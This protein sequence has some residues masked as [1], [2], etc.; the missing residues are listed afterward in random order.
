ML[1][2]YGGWV[3]VDFVNTKKY[4]L[5]NQRY[6]T[7]AKLMQKRVSEMILSKQ[8]ATVAIAIALAGDGFLA[9]NIKSKNISDKY[10][11]NLSAKFRKN[12]LYKNIWIQIIDKNL[13]SL[14]RSWTDKKG[15]N[16]RDIR[17]DIADAI[18]KKEVIYSISV[19]KFDLSI[20]AIV[21]IFE[22]KEIVGALEVISHFNSIEKQMKK[23]DVDSMV[24]LDK[25]YTKQL[26][27][28]YTNIFVDEYY[29]A[30][31]DA[32][33]YM[34]KYL[35][36]T[37]I[38]E[39]YSQ[40][41]K[42]IQ[43]NLVTTYKL[44]SIDKELIGYYI[45]SKNI[46]NIPTVDLD[47]FVFKW[48]ALGLIGIMVVAG[49][50]NISLFYLMR[51]QKVYYKS[52]IDSSRNIV[53]VNDGKY[54]VDANKMFF[55]YFNKY[56]SLEEFRQ[57]HECVCDFFIE[58]GEYIGKT[59][60][61]LTWIDYIVKNQKSIN[62]VKIKYA[63]ETYYFMLNAVLISKEDN[64]YSV[65]F[66]DITNEEHYKHQLE[67][68]SI[69]DM[70]TGIGNRRYFHTK[71][72]DEIYNCMRYKHPLSIVM[73]DIDYFK[74]IN[75][76]YGHKVGDDVLIE[77]TRFISSMLRESDIF[78]RIGGEEFVILLPYSAKSDAQ[79]IAEKLRIGVEEHKE[80]VPITVSFGVSQYIEN[81]DVDSILKRVDDA[82]Y[83]AKNGGRN[84]VV[85]K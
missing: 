5:K 84:M 85:V 39:F 83:E 60:K 4:E 24:V 66:S 62:K 79:K 48:I 26:K 64:Y 59:V 78:C 42:I 6:D 82:L 38:K 80:V 74:R 40:T 75:D 70:L 50:I 33:L 57:E 22:D 25:K 53:M 65:V 35:K 45:M 61:G 63:D 14:Y 31:F 81:E 52:I 20:K 7:Q 19:G 46:K 28:P 49:I 51:K 37:D 34:Q 36:N 69:T 71:I 68:W 55:T 23:F 18:N 1:L 77:Y 67:N 17:K 41:Y 73:F 30:N 56:N 3:Y 27:Y 76:K 2:L 10:Y 44:E 72:N 29:I 9:Q 8:K 32:P 58:E 16:L 12:T 13:N 15:D 21:P 47:F 11:K 54:I 43:N